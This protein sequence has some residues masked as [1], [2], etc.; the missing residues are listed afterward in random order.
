MTARRWCAVALVLAF[1]AGCGGGSD[2][3]PATK[4]E[5]GRPVSDAEALILARLLERNY[6]DGGARF[7]GVVTFPG[8]TRVAI[9]GV[10]DWRR[11]GGRADLREAGHP[12]R[13]S[14]RILWNKRLV[15][16]QAGR[17]GAAS[18]RWD[19]AAADR[20][21]GPVQFYLDFLALLSARNID[22]VA[23]IRDRGARFRGTDEV[24]GVPVRIFDLGAGTRTSYWVGIEDQR[25]HRVETRVDRYG[26]DAAL[27]FT[28]RGPRRIKLPPRSEWR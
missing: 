23:L 22:N 6:S 4:S 7:E 11:I 5:A 27:T 26:G 24:D 21:A 3:P 8:P 15:L 16:A 19:P 13:D 18:R 2:E 10:V 1:I 17:A 20:D 25:L 12:A 9:R 28:A 14:R